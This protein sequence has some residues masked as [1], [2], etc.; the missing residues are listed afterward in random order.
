M[1]LFINDDWALALELGADGVHLGQ[2]DL[3]QADLAIIARAGL[4]LGVSTHSE[5]EF[6]RALAL[7]PLLYCLRPVFEPLSKIALCPI[8]CGSGCA[9]CT[10]LSRLYLTCIGGI[11]EHNAA[12]VWAT[13]IGSVAV[14]TALANDEQLEER[15]QGLKGPN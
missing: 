9:L 15:V 7:T 14:V 3:A 6:A 11:T 1:L 5:W 13:G 2:E 10:K 8:G 4:Y 12:F